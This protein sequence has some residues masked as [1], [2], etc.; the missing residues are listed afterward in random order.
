MFLHKEQLLTESLRDRG[1]QS[2][3]LRLSI[4]VLLFFFKSQMV[5]IPFKAVDLIYRV[6]NCC[7]KQD[8]SPEPLCILCWSEPTYAAIYCVCL[9]AC[10]LDPELGTDLVL[11]NEWAM[12]GLL[13]LPHSFCQTSANRGLI[14]CKTRQNVTLNNHFVPGIY[15][16]GGDMQGLVSGGGK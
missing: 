1:W 2:T 8:K 4:A 3:E 14:L 15:C 12:H 13:R 16:F 6:S 11:L 5:T 7:Y 9:C 10:V